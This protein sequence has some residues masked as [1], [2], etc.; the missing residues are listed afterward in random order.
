MVH[1]WSEVAL[2][3]LAEPAGTIIRVPRHLAE[4]PLDA[5]LR[6]A[7]GLPQ[8]QRADFRLRLDRDR[9]LHVRDFGAFYEAHIDETDPEHGTL[10]R[11]LRDAPGAGVTGTAVLG[12]LL[13]LLLGRS[14]RALVAGLVA[15]AALGAVAQRAARPR[16]ARRTTAPMIP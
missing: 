10:L 5:G 3:L 16:D 8:G 14:P 1:Q 4:H 2:V 9:A 7:L 11:A 6:P 12:G 15:G 13:G